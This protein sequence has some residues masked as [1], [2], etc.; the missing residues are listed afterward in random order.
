MS[1]GAASGQYVPMATG[2]LGTSRGGAMVL[3]SSR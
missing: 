1:I 2:Y 3:G